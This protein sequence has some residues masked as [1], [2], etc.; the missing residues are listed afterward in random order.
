MLEIRTEH[1]QIY[2]P[3]R[4]KIQSSRSGNQEHL[5]ASKGE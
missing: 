5:I 1:R 3:V 2:K 4:A